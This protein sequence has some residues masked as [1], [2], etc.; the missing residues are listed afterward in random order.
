MKEKGDYIRRGDVIAVIGD[1]AIMYAKLSVDENNISKIKAGQS[2]LVQLNTEKERRYQGKVKE[3][4]PYFDEMN[5]SFFCK[6]YF[7]EAPETLLA[8]TQ[9]QCN[10]E[11]GKKKN[12]LVIPREYLGYGNTVNVKG[13]G[14]VTVKTGFISGEWVEIISGLDESSVIISDQ[15]K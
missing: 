3:I 1:E 12:A 10:I 14:P 4:L 15:L 7:E 8:G 6:F 11:T 13:I 2:G 9:L 5:Q